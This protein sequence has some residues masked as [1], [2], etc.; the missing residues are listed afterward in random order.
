[1]SFRWNKKKFPNPPLELDFLLNQHPPPVRR[2]ISVENNSL[3][4]VAQGGGGSRS[5]ITQ[6]KA[7]PDDLC[8]V[9]FHGLWM[10]EGLF[11][12]VV[13]LKSS[14]RNKFPRKKKRKFRQ[15]NCVVCTLSTQN[16]NFYH[17]HFAQFSGKPNV[18]FKH[19]HK[20]NSKL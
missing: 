18:L 19:H 16:S 1:M 13:L 9:I 3:Q 8:F 14:R 15:P 20:L 7:L 4:V 6:T 12:Y 2:R 10:D 17:K 5:R 11:F